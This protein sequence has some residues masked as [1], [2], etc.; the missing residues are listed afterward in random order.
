MNKPLV[1]LVVGTTAIII[2]S[3][4][5]FFIIPQSQ[6]RFS[7]S[8]EKMMNLEVYRIFTFH[9]THV[10]LN[11][12]VENIFALTLATI[13]ALELGVTGKQF[14]ITFFGTS[15]LIALTESPIFPGI[16]MTGA[17]A[18][19]AALLGYLSIKGKNFISS[20][21]LI[22][23]FL[24]PLM[25]KYILAVLR[26]PSGALNIAELVFH[27]SGF[28]VGIAF[29][30]VLTKVKIRKTNILQVSDDETY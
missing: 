19:I 2:L 3:L 28:I 14:L 16:L 12:L 27:L 21:I 22:P 11:H 15:V 23:V 29:F 17:S 7:Y 18:G 24:M 4:V 20:A 1:L 10:T 6:E 5:V 13:L 8:N 9:F 25:Y 30:F 26:N